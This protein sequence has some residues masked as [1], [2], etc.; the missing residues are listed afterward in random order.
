MPNRILRDGII[1]SEQVNAL[2]PS[3]E[4]FYRRLM[5]KADDFGRFHGHPALILAA[6][7]P[8][9][10]DR[11][12]MGDIK[13]W[14]AECRAIGLILEYEADGKRYI[15]IIK[16]G[17]RTRTE[18]KFPPPNVRD[19]LPIVREMPPNGSGL[20]ARAR[21][22]SESESYAESESQSDKTA[23]DIAPVPN[24]EYPLVI[25]EIRKHDPAV[26]DF[27]VLRLVQA[28]VQHCISSPSFPQDKLPKVTDKI[29][30]RAVA[31]S[32]NTGPPNHRAGLLL[33]RVPPILVSWSID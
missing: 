33:K 23:A 27:F 31:E 7:Y 20:H 3:A 32:Y 5:S 12:N 30:A 18:S 9:Q 19:V 28:C 1:E 16:F 10:L 2:T 21:A 4:L 24:G 15:E 13:A 14:L 26:D 11:V 29:I 6:C 8:L 22:R 25:T 17:Q